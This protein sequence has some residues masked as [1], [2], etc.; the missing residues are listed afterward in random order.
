MLRNSF[1]VIALV[2]ATVAL[3]QDGNNESTSGEQN[4]SQSSIEESET[5]E[6]AE[7]IETPDNFDPT[8][9]VVEDFSVAFPVDI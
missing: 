1:F 9:K 7:E 5:T 6:Q 2:F 4:L 8:E 3:A